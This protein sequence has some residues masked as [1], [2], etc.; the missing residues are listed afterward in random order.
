MMHMIGYVS[1]WSSWYCYSGTLSSDFK[2]LVECIFSQLQWLLTHL[3]PGTHISV[4]VI[5]GLGNGFVPV[6]HQAITW[7]NAGYS[8]LDQRKQT[9]VTLFQNAILYQTSLSVVYLGMFQV[10][11]T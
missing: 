4:I 8:Q 5:I 9:S 10:N 3:G 6:G 1:W 2:G 11:F 7:S